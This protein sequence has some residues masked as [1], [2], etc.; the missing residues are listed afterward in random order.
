MAKKKK[1]KIFVIGGVVLVVLILVIWNLSRSTDKKVTVQ[2]MEVVR[3][4]AA[5][6]IIFV[7]GPV[8]GSRNSVVQIRSAVKA[9]K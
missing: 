3:V 6:N 2:G 9:S 4:F 8:P 5:D 7:K 1:K